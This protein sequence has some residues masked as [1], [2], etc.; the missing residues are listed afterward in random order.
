MGREEVKPPQEVADEHT[1]L[2]QK[3]AGYLVG[4]PYRNAQQ[5]LQIVIDRRRRWREPALAADGCIFCVHLTD[6]GAERRVAGFQ[7]QLDIEATRL[8]QRHYTDWVRSGSPDVSEPGK[9]FW[10]ESQA[11]LRRFCE[12]FQDMP[13]ERRPTGWNTKPLP[14]IRLPLRLKRK[15]C[16]EWGHLLLKWMQSEGLHYDFTDRVFYREVLDDPPEG[17]REPVLGYDCCGW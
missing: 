1:L 2:A 11:N 4:H 12:L 14:I 13:T 8:K 17:A 6:E 10:P 16:I 3:Y 15:L 9:L 7:Y 5:S